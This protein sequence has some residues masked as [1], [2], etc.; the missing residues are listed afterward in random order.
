MKKSIF[1]GKSTR[2]KIYSA[3]TIIAI[4]LLLCLN[5]LL[6]HVFNHNVLIADLTPEG[7]YS[8]SDRMLEVCHEMLDPDEDGKTKE[9]EIIFCTDPDY[10][11]ANEATR[12]TYFMALQ[13]QRE[14]DNVSVKEIN[15]TLNPTAVAAYKTTSRDSISPSDIIV[16][17]GSKYRIAGAESFW[18]KLSTDEGYFSYNGEY[19]MASII[20]SITAIYQP[21]AYFVTDHGETYYDPNDTG[22]EMSKSMG[23][24]AD[25][26]TERGLR[27][28]TIALSDENVKKIPDDCVLLI[29]NNPKEDLRDYPDRYDEFNYVSESEMLDRYLVKD[30]GA[31]FINKAH[32]NAKELPN[33]D[34]FAAEW[35]IAFGD[36]QIFDP[37]NSLFYGI[38]ED[39][40]DS[41]FAGVYD[42]NEENFGYAYYGPYSTLTSS[43]KMVFSNTGYVYCAFDNGESMIEAGNM[44]GSR[45]YAAFIGTSENTYHYENGNLMSPSEKTLMAASVRKNLDSYT[46]ESVS[47]YLFCTN[48]ADFFSNDLLGNES[49]ANYDIVSSVINDISRTDKYATSD[50][51]GLGNSKN[52]GGKQMVSTTLSTSPTDVL[53]PDLQHIIKTNKGITKGAIVAYTVMVMAVPTAILAFGIV[54]FIKRK[55]L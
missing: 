1:K 18:T 49:Y 45:N 40:D 9:I 51:G 23:Y 29:I 33:L 54:V 20:A 5:L 21:A 22:S 6:T 43:P 28:E 13:L 53:T 34:R 10:L 35:G 26:L 12:V 31:I 47:S 50:L 38:G 3:I 17:Y 52:F 19:K 44:Q 27:I 39:L 24:L 25:L 2:T 30:Y 41:V 16:A 4:C 15:V 37:D 48:S 8:L 46:G 14:F 55:F 42:S 7:I 36:E 11:V 32:D